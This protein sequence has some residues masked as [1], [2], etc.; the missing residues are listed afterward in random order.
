VQATLGAGGR[1]SGGLAWGGENGSMSAGGVTFGSAALLA[2]TMLL[3]LP[4]DVGSLGYLS[5][6]FAEET[7][8][9]PTSFKELMLDEKQMTAD[10]LRIDIRGVFLWDAH[11]TRLY[12][13]PFPH[14][15]GSIALSLD[16]LP[17]SVKELLYDNCGNAC[18][19]RMVGKLV[20]RCDAGAPCI[21]VESAAIERQ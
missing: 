16:D 5:P 17:R 12:D 8:A 14:H 7:A 3:A 13:A 21:S 15:K 2:V 10:H 1:E 9:R 4:T 19:V 20:P 6:T 11:W 18:S